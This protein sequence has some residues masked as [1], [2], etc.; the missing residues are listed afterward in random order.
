MLSSWQLYCLSMNG[1][2]HRRERGTRLSHKKH[3]LH[4][5]NTKKKSPSRLIIATKLFPSTRTS[6]GLVSTFSSD[7]LQ[8]LVKPRSSFILLSFQLD[9]Y[10][11]FLCILCPHG[12]TNRRTES[13][14][15]SIG[16]TRTTGTTP[17]DRTVCRNT[18]QLPG[19]RPSKHQ[20][21]SL[22][23]SVAVYLSS[24]KRNGIISL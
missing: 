20:H 18:P 15:S 22:S 12:E 13:L 3:P 17:S 23:I 8:P 4:P 24:T 10:P 11:R 7:H 21:F 16:H 19:G 6:T 14:S 1:M 9:I 2:H 5:E